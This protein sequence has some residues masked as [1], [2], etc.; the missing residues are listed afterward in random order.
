MYVVDVAVAYEDEGNSMSAIK[1]SKIEKYTQIVEEARNTL[2]GSFR[3]IVPVNA[4]V[5]HRAIVFGS[6]VGMLVSTMEFY[7]LP[8]HESLVHTPLQ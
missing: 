4:K 2:E 6:R 3:I 1:N 7:D 8:W 5:E